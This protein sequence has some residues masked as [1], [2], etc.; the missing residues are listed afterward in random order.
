VSVCL[1]LV[2]VGYRVVDIEA[3]S[4]SFLYEVFLVLYLISIC[5]ASGVD[6]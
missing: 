3:V 2:G 5:M 4:Y 6:V 1:I